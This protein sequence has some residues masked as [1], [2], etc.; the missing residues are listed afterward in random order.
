[1]AASR[2]AQ[3][4]RIL[5]NIAESRAGR[6][7]SKFAEYAAAEGRIANAASKSSTALVPLEHAYHYTMEKYAESI[8]SEGLR[9]ERYATPN[10]NLSALQAHI[11]LALSPE[12]AL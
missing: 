7:A 2:A 4:A 5:A 9:A 11:E 8:R 10:G 6:E 12:S 1:A 3:R